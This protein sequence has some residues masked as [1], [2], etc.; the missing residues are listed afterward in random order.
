MNM[1][2][3]NKYFTILFVTLLFSS[4]LVD[5][6]APSDNNDS[7]PNIAGFAVTSQNLSAVADG[8][9]REFGIVVELKG[10][11][12][13]EATEDVTLTVASEPGSTAIEGVHYEFPSSSITLTKANNYFGTLPITVI[14]EGVEAPLTAELVLSVA[15]ATGTNV[16]ANGNTITLNFV[17]QCF[18]DLSGTYSVT[19]DFCFPSF[20]T[21]CTADPDGSWYLGVADGGFLHTCTSNTSLLNW[22]NITE[23]CGEILPGGDL[24]FGTAGFSGAIGD[25]VGGTWDAENG[26]ISMSHT[27]NFFNG[28]PYA[29]NST[30]TRQ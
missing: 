23:L 7:G 8:N 29:W 6:E 12:L 19:N 1:K 3:F 30:Y 24:R 28:G 18:A 16:V 10:P 9:T 2:K 27:E 20:T 21:E 14:T 5:D 17:Y 15:S 13:R 25:I 22:G 26:I 4:C 11:G